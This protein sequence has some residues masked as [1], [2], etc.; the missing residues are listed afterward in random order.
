MGYSFTRI[1]G[2]AKPLLSRAAIAGPSNKPGRAITPVLAASCRPSSSSFLTPYERY[3]DA[4]IIVS[5]ITFS[6]HGP[7]EGGPQ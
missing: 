7:P 2:P 1:F 4:N 5:Q 3:N 6:G